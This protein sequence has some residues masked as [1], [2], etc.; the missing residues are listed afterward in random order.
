M[1]FVIVSATACVLASI[2]QCIPIRKAWD[3]GGTLSGSCINVNALFF[4]NAGLDIFQD[5]LIYIL[6]MRMLY[7]IQI[8]KRQRIA[9]MMVF[10]VG[11]FVVITGMIRLNY[12]K[13]AQNSPDPSYNNYGGA[14]WSAIECNIGVVCASLPAFKPLIDHLFPTLMGHSRGPSKVTPHEVTAARRHGYRR[15]TSQSDLELENGAAWETSY[16]ALKNY[17]SNA[18]AEGGFASNARGSKEHL[19]SIS[20]G[21]NNGIWKS[22]KVEVS[23]G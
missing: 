4:A 12:L 19:Q 17:T 3:T 9:L 8:P 14:V 10:A 21:S 15:K 2:F 18:T 1:I 7:K 11:G 13:V 20:A 22:T 23:H 16:P 5:A 6:P